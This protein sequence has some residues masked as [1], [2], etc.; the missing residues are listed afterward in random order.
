VEV[1]PIN[2]VPLHT[3]APL[4][5]TAVVAH[6]VAD[7]QWKHCSTAASLFAGAAEAADRASV[8]TPTKMPI[9]L[10]KPSRRR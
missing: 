3:A 4:L 7:R 6:I 5:T 8:A 9:V 10:L 2:P 1:L